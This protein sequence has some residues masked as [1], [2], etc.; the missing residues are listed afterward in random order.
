MDM[1]N[2]LHLSKYSIFFSYLVR[3][4]AAV[5]EHCMLI[6]CSSTACLLYAGIQKCSR[7]ELADE[8]GSQ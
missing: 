2:I 1:N 6:A 4:L 8:M 7:G 3:Y 5:F